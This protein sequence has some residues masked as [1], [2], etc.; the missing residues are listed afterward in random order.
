MD[1]FTGPGH[2]VWS[3]AESLHAVKLQ[4]PDGRA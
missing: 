2:S 4:D 3:L 1:R